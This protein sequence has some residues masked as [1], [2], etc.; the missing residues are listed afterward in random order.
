M[1]EFSGTLEGVG[2]PA[3]VRFLAGL[4]KTGCLRITHQ[5]WG[6]EIHFDRGA[7]VSATLGSR[8]GL[9]AL[10]ALVQALP[11]AAFVFDGDARWTAEPNSCENLAICESEMAAFVRALL[12]FDVTITV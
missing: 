6:G 7:I 3:I 9:S 8:K 2:L 4:E 12:G 5:D 10:D 1:T 11:G